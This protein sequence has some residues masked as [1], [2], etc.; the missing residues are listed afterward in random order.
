MFFYSVIMNICCKTI[1]NNYDQ[2]IYSMQVIQKPRWN[3]VIDLHISYF[4]STQQTPVVHQ[5]LTIRI[6]NPWSLTWNLNKSDPGKGDPELGSHHFNGSSPK[7]LGVGV[8]HVSNKYSI[9]ITTLQG[10]EHFAAGTEPKHKTHGHPTT[11]TWCASSS[12]NLKVFF[13]WLMGGEHESDSSS[14]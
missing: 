4:T 14:I 3:W 1:I 12:S 11:K 6:F 9:Y 10:R 5:I 2:S 8:P 7:T 13:G